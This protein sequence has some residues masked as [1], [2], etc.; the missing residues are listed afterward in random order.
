MWSIPLTY[1]QWK[2][3]PFEGTFWWYRDGTL[4]GTPFCCGQLK[5]YQSGVLMSLLISNRAL[6]GQIP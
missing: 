2:S 6:R 3:L 5:E 1:M 4:Y